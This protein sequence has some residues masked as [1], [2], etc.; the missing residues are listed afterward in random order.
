MHEH[1][2]GNVEHHPIIS[3]AEMEVHE[4]VPEA[5]KESDRHRRQALEDK[6]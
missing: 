3:K 5:Q 2:A 1:Y 4:V 6:V